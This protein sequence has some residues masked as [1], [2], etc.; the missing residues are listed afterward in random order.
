MCYALKTF[1]HIEFGS[2]PVPH[3]FVPLWPCS[4]FAGA[5]DGRYVALYVCARTATGSARAAASSSTDGAILGDAKRQHS[6]D[7][8]SAGSWGRV[9]IAV[10]PRAEGSFCDRR[11]G[12]PKRMEAV[13]PIRICDSARADATVLC[14]ALKH[15][16]LRKARDERVG[17]GCGVLGPDGFE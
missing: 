11:K 5:F 9:Y 15:P 8:A 2:E 7:L 12:D 14:L 17:A 4:D 13:L 10:L 3:W 6:D 16:W 1:W